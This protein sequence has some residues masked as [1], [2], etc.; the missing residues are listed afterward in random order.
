V[1]SDTRWVG[2]L[3]REYAHLTDDE[4]Q[5][6]VENTLDSHS[7]EWVEKHL[8]L[9]VHCTKEVEILRDVLD[10]TSP[11]DLNMSEDE[12]RREAVRILDRI[13]ERI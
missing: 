2:N 1:K 10:D 11:D 6:Y 13:R 5:G 4:I 7:L 3:I 12:V 8:R 9:C